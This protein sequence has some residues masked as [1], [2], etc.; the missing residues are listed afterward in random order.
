MSK[1]GASWNTFKRVSQTSHNISQP[2]SHPSTNFGMTSLS[3]M[4][5]H[6]ME[7]ESLSLLSSVRRSSTFSTRLTREC[8]PCSPGQS[9]LSSGLESRLPLSSV[10]SDAVTATVWH[11]QTQVLPQHQVPCQHIPSNR[12]VGTTSNFRGNTISLSLTA[13]DSIHTE[14]TS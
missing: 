10:W 3:W 9:P 6:Y 14:M 11:H 7:T 12:Y 8:P 4:A 13:I 1:C 2:L 5:W